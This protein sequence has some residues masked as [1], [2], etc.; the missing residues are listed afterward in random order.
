MTRATKRSNASTR[1][2]YLELVERET[3]GLK[4]A[5]Y[6]STGDAVVDATSYRVARRAAG[7]AIAAVEASVAE[8]RGGLCARSSARSP[9]RAGSRH[10]FLPLQQRRDRRARLS[11]RGRIGRVLIVDFDYHH[12]NGTEAVAGSRPLV[13]FDARLSRVP[14]DGHA[15][16]SPR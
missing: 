12:G 11:S 13:L 9:R 10:G 7:G 1:A 3:A 15:Q 6:L 4:E 16:L 5:R 8:K 14:R 2:A